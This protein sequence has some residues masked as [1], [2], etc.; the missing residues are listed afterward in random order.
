MGMFPYHMQLHS[1]DLKTTDFI[2]KNKVISGQRA[3]RALENFWVPDFLWNGSS[4]QVGAIKPGLQG[5]HYSQLAGQEQWR[6]L[7][8]QNSQKPE[9]SFFSS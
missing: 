6:V 7:V 2:V 4:R 3:K 5:K 9:E 1:A 8:Q